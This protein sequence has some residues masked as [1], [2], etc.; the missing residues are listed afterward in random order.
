MDGFQ[1]QITYPSLIK[2]IESIKLLHSGLK[3]FVGAGIIAFILQVGHPD[4]VH[5]VVHFFLSH[6]RSCFSVG[7]T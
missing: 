5:E 1:N 7:G 2:S 3:C 6:L 4:S